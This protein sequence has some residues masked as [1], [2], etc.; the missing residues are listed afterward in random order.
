MSQAALRMSQ[1]SRRLPIGADPQ[2]DGST[3]FRVWAPQPREVALVIE[4]ANGKHHEVRLTDEG[5]GY[6]AA[7][8]AEVGPGRRY[9]YQLDGRLFADPTS[10]FQPDGPFG[11]SQI[12]DSFSW[13][14][15]D[16]AWPGITMPGQ[17]FYELHVGTFTPAGTWRA[18]MEHLSRL[19]GTGITAVEVMPVSDFPGRFG[20]GYDGVFPYAP[21]HLYG[22][23][24]DFRAF[25]DRAHHLGLAV[26]LDVVYNHFGPSG[27][28]HREYAHAYFTD[29]YENEWGDPLNFD[30]PGAGPV[31]EYFTAN[32]AYWISEFH[33]DGLRLDAIQSIND[34]SPDHLVAAVA[35]HAR[36]AA[37]TREIVIV[38]ENESQDIRHVRLDRAKGAIDAVWND[39]FHHSAVVAMTGRREAYY[40][41]HRGA[42]QEFISAA[43]RGF[44]FQGQRYHWQKKPR[45]TRTD[46]IPP[47]AFVNFIENHDQIANSGDG[48]RLH[49]RV[50]PGRYRAF[51]ALLLLLPSTPMLFQGQEFGASSP[52][53]YF[54]DHQGELADAVL[55]GRAAFIAQFPSL[56]AKAAQACMPAPH[57]PMTFERCK[58]RWEEWDTN[59]AHRLLHTDL[60]ALRR[61]DVAFRQQRQDAV[62]GAVLGDEAFVLRYATRDPHDERLLVVNFGPDLV[63]GSL[64]EPLVAPPDGCV[65]RMHW[66]SE[67]VSYGGVGAYPIV[68]ASGW[69]VPAHSATVLAPEA[70]DASTR[71]D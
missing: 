17:V 19:K 7:R 49:R 26:I 70:A 14:W 35:R 68:T 27:S 38:A 44:L 16:S 56:A 53:L 25:V 11:A 12:V 41:D 60:L 9:W 3:H 45:G 39:D 13:R 29:R 23:P 2:P 31:R 33:L 59:Q 18:A 28:V 36:Q 15:G 65:W 5:E 54:A 61:S 37:G 40:S 20:W 8:V 30:G 64:A 32:A 52:F 43:K 71:K 1:V 66:S 63:E 24:D 34:H 46:G 62:D 6:F 48:S 42:P 22:A 10:R 4:E 55:K 51:T 57:D 47:A 21:C 58:V 50:S 69:R 67:D